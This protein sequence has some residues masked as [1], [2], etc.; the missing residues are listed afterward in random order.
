MMQPKAT[1]E[2]EWRAESDA[3]T[4]QEAATISADKSRFLKAQEAAKKIL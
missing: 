1:S 3:R 4:L 2:D